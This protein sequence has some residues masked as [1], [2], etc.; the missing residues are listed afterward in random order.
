MVR[1]M[2]IL[3]SIFCVVLLSSYSYSEEISSDQVIIKRGGIVYEVNP[4]SLQK[5]IFEE[6]YTPYSGTI[7]YLHENGQLQGRENYK[8]GLLD[9]LGK[10]FFKNGQLEWR[11]NWREGKSNG[12]WEEFFENGQLEWIGNYKDGKKDGL[13]EGFWDNGQLEWIGS[14]KDGKEDGMWEGFDENGQIEFTSYYIN[15]KKVKRKK[16]LKRK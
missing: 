3:L 9:G 15:G 12:L 13:W 5:F 1:H 14:F 16:Y 6:T 7:L 10:D 2:K 8:D 11:I 4:K